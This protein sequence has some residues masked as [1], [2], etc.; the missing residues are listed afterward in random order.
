MIGGD[1]PAEPVLDAM[2]LAQNRFL[3]DGGAAIPGAKR[4]AIVV[5]NKDARPRT[6]AL[7]SDV[8]EGLSAKEVGQ[9]LLRSRISVFALQ[10]GNEDQ[11]HLIRV[12]STLA[13]ETG[14]EFYRSR[15]LSD[16]IR[17]DFSR[18]LARL[19][20]SPIDEGRRVGERLRPRVIERPGGGTVIP[21][22]V[23]DEDVS[24]RLEATAREY[25][26]SSVGL[27]IAK[28]WLFEE[29][30]LYREEILIE[31]ELL[32]WLLRFFNV[33]TDSALSAELLRDS[34][35][36]L[37]EAL[38]GE[39]LRERVNLK[40]LLEK[41]LG[42]HFTTNLLSFDI[43]H[44]V[45]LDR[46]KRSLLQKRIRDATAALEDFYEENNL[47][48]DREPRIWMPVQYLP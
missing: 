32:E 15:V 30:A 36:S 48:F 14:G 33:M 5:A 11:G 10:A 44:L 41:R 17:T 46:V 31:K 7:T 22:N 25:H 8:Q 26:V 27:V 6:V 18:N 21:V 19:L 47:R 37:L 12:L 23:I 3:W 39:S 43:E 20:R 42:I 35:A 29:P 9:R 13:T 4:I 34:M 16:E 1:D 38:T 45:T 24:T 40:E 2:I 28:A